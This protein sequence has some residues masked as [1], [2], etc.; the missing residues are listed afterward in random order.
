MKA[1]TLR[2][3]E[4]NADKKSLAEIVKIMWVRDKW[5]YCLL[6]PGVLYF[7][8]FRYAPM[9][10]VI[11]AF[12]NYVPFLGIQASPWVGLDHFT[13]FFS[14]PDFLRLLGNTLW[15]SFLGIAVAFPAPIFLAIL[16]NEIRFSVYKKLVQTCIYVPHFLSWTIVIGLTH[17]LFSING[18]AVVDLVETIFGVR[19]NFLAEPQWFRPMIIL[20]G[21]WK[22][23]GWGTIIF[24]AALAN[25]SP[26]QYEAAIVDGAGRF[27]RIWH[28]TLPAIRPTVVIMLILTMGSVLNT[29]FDQIFLMTNSLNRSVADVF[30]TYVYNVGI[31]RGSYSYS[32]AVGLFKSLVGIILILTTDFIAKKVDKESG[33]F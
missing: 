5:L 24:L 4:K 22:G 19:I 9:Y 21:I 20:Q 27:R 25:V 18:G 17:V 3:P 29:G 30:D 26:E 10:G 8:I 12:K 33:L 15:L 6:I 16:L 13:S 28:I 7:L 32:T 11:I 2:K 14:S 23:T 1:I 31:T